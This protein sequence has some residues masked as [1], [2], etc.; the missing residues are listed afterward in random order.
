MIARYSRWAIQE[1]RITGV[2]PRRW[3]ERIGWQRARALLEAGEDKAS[4]AFIAALQPSL[5]NQTPEGGEG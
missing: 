1:K 3:V 4:C 2:S 5:F